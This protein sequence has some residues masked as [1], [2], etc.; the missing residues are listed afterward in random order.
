MDEHERLGLSRSVYEGLRDRFVHR[1]YKGR[2]YCYLPDYHGPLERGTVIVEDTVVRGFPKIPRTLVLET[3]IP[4]HF[5]DSLVVEEKLNGYNARVVS[6][7][8][9]TYAFTRSGIICPF[10]THVVTSGLDL[11]AFFAAHPDVMLCG[12][13]IGPENPYT[14][15]DYPGVESIAFR[16]FDIRDR[17]SGMPL[18]IEARQR[19]CES[20]DI[21]QVPNLGSYTTAEAVTAVPTIVRELSAEGREGVVLKSFNGTRQLKYTTSAGNQDDL[22]YAFALPFDRGQ[23]FMFRRLIREAFQSVEWDEGPDA[24]RERAQGLGESILY[25]MVEA[26]RRIDAGETVGERHTVRGDPAVLDALLAHF[27]DLG[28]HIAVEADTREGDERVVTFLKQT[29]ATNDRTRTYLDGHIVH[30]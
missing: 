14:T 28:L 3:G 2:R 20:Y 21:P 25:P 23:S 9:A 7:G 27:R 13:V 11:D 6:I 12:E 18:S 16:A 10:T 30:E 5:T 24:V 26:I 4:R 22:S 8:G 1:T 15:A 29:Q 19:L 17:E